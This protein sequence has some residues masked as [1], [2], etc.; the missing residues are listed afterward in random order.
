M[1]LSNL[2]C[3]ALDTSIWQCETLVLVEIA[4]VAEAAHPYVAIALTRFFAIA[5]QF[6]RFLPRL[7]P[8]GFE[9]PFLF[10]TVHAYCRIR[11]RPDAFQSLLLLANLEV[12]IFGGT[13]VHKS[14]LPM[15]RCS[16]NFC[17]AICEPLLALRSPSWA[18]PP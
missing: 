8:F 5:A 3:G 10:A 7:G 15:M 13:A 9:R 4:R 12:R 11:A 16:F 2:S 14:H 1:F 17:S 18:F 6:G